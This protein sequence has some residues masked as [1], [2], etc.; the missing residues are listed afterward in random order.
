MRQ[1][2]NVVKILTTIREVRLVQTAQTIVRS[3]IGAEV[4]QQYAL[5]I[6]TVELLNWITLSGF[7]R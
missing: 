6:V 3:M 5:A 2:V 4:L 7:V 1:P